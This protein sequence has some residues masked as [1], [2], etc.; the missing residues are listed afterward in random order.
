MSKAQFRLQIPKKLE[1]GKE[2]FSAGTDRKDYE[3][4]LIL[5]GPER[6]ENLDHLEWRQHPSKWRQRQ[7]VQAAF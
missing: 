3:I 1:E 5:P 6:R 7:G 4:S 2:L